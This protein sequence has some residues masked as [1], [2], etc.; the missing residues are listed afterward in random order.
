VDFNEQNEECVILE[1]TYL[2]DSVTSCD[3][4][5][6]WDERKESEKNARILVIATSATT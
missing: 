3:E 5:G 1:F 6:D 4:G 2:L